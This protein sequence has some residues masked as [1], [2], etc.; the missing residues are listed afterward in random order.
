MRQWGFWGQPN[1]PHRCPDSFIKL[2]SQLIGLSPV[3]TT[4]WRISL[5]KAV[6]Y[7]CNYLKRQHDWTA[8][9]PNDRH[10]DPMTVPG[11]GRR[12][13]KARV[14]PPNCWSL[15]LC[16]IASLIWSGHHVH[17]FS[18]QPLD[19]HG[20]YDLRT[21][22]AEAHQLLYTNEDIKFATPRWET[23][24]TFLVNK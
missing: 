18:R 5:G 9:L 23:W 10:R 16:M 24:W 19:L 14:T 2:V 21:L 11:I 1:D 13:P 15:S 17:V 12:C 6:D 8:Y 7:P 20:K 4:W 22:L 3:R